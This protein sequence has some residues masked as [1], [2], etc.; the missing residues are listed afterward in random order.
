MM[1]MFCY[2]R[3]N[4]EHIDQMATPYY[5]SITK[6][7]GGK[8]RNFLSHMFIYLPEN[9]TEPQIELIFYNWYNKEWR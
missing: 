9:Y 3:S 2:V 6:T 7:K 4:F 8:T 1:R 5:S